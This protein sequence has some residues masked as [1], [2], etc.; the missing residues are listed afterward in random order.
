MKLTVLYA[1]MSVIP[2]L[3]IRVMTFC[4]LNSYRHR[5]NSVGV[6]FYIS[7]ESLA[8][9]KMT[10]PDYLLVSFESMTVS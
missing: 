1:D 8:L 4:N 10:A 2:E 9:L 6:E 3:S 5:A 7:P